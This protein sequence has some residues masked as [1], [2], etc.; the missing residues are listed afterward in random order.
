MY[1]LVAKLIGSELHRPK[2]DSDSD[3]RSE[4]HTSYLVDQAKPNER[5]NYRT[6]NAK[7]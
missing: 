7:E 5:R 4:D 3:Q 2:S 1:S 6:N